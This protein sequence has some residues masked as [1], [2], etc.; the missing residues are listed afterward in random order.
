VNG[1]LRNNIKG[2]VSSERRKWILYC[3]NT[4]SKSRHGNLTHLC[5]RVQGDKVREYLGVY[6][7]ISSRARLVADHDEIASEI[8]AQA[9]VWISRRFP[10]LA[11]DVTQN[12]RGRHTHYITQR[13]AVF[14]IVVVKMREKVWFLLTLCF[15]YMVAT[16]VGLSEGELP[17]RSNHECEETGQRNQKTVHNSGNKG[18]LW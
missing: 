3:K 11:G 7:E 6:P 4:A 18:L 14:L 8:V 13:S 15:G 10:D 17:I 5:H 2:R 1:T 12:S 9:N 16:Y